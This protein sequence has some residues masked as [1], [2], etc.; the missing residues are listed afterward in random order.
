MLISKQMDPTGVPRLMQRHDDELHDD[1]RD[2]RITRLY[3][4]YFS[5]WEN[6]AGLQKWGI[7]PSDAAGP[8]ASQDRLLFDKVQTLLFLLHTKA[9]R[10]ARTHT[11]TTTHGLCVFVL[12][13]GK[14]V[15]TIKESLQL[16]DCSRV[17]PLT[18]AYI[19]YCLGLFSCRVGMEAAM[20]WIIRW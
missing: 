10:H 11:C 1:A 12:V 15:C 19:V 9:R 7:A 17:W 16:T 5:V 13:S 3:S 2:F 8:C 14:A 18:Q 6:A 20:R 4:P